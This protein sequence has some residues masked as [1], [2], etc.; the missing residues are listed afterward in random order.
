MQGRL[1]KGDGRQHDKGVPDQH[2]R[3]C[4]VQMAGDVLAKAS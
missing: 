1:S 4:L 2:D 3:S